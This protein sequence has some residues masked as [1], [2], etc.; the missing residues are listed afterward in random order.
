[1]AMGQKKISY[2]FIKTATTGRD[3][4]AHVLGDTDSLSGGRC[5]LRRVAT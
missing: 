4:Q 3:W 5:A 2:A 1:M